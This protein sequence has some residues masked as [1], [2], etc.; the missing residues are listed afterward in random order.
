[1]KVD[2]EGHERAAL[3]GCEKASTSGARSRR[4]DR[5]KRHGG[6]ATNRRLVAGLGPIR[7]SGSGRRPVGGRATR[8]DPALHQE[9]YL[10]EV[11]PGSSCQT[12]VR[13]N[14]RY[15]NN[16]VSGTPPCGDVRDNTVMCLAA[17]ISEVAWLPGAAYERLR[18]SVRNDDLGKR[19]PHR[20]TAAG[21]RP[22]GSL[23]RTMRP[24]RP[25]SSAVRGD[26]YVPICSCT[27]RKASKTR[28]RTSTWITAGCEQGGDEIWDPSIGMGTA[29]SRHSVHLPVR[30]F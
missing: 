12:I 8:F 11:R 16:V 9:K 5:G 7:R 10:A 14:A 24:R 2:V 27:W 23:P 26:V 29:Q 3:S 20:R 21:R 1:M 15:I 19:R 28:S 4:R 18:S 22:A 13:R 30:T 6:I 17:R 25:W